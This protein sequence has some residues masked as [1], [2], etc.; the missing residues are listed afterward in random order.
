LDCGCETNGLELV[1]KKWTRG[2]FVLRGGR[3]QE[4]S[5]TNGEKYRGKPMGDD[6]NNDI[7]CELCQQRTAYHDHEI[8]REKNLKKQKVQSG[9][10]KLNTGRSHG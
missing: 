5:G 9:V 10:E 3:G 7:L 6:P 4:K 8:D 2:R 1:L